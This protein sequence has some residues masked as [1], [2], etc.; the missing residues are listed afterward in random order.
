MPILYYWIEIAGNGAENVSYLI[1]NYA[2]SIPNL[3][4]RF[5]WTMLVISLSLQISQAVW[6]FL[7]VGAPFL[8]QNFI[9]RDILYICILSNCSL[10]FIQ[11]NNNSYFSDKKQIFI[12]KSWQNNNLR[13]RG[14]G[15]PL[16]KRAN[17]GEPHN[18]P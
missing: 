17:E 3:A 10:K 15:E 11:N 12:F 1:Y 18:C 13:T 2:V 16:P 5:P 14:R 8:F 9:L 6:L 7:E 4:V